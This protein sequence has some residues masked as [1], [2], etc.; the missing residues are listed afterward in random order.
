MNIVPTTADPTDPRLMRGEDTE[1]REMAEAY[2]V[3]SEEERHKK[4]VRPYRDTYVHLACHQL[5]K[6][7]LE[8]AETYARNPAFYGYT[9]CCNCRMHRP[10]NEFRWED[11]T[12]VGS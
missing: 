7:T 4:F 12:Q 2:L 3:L 8:I 10:L 6:M 5:T 11:G 9:Y 1:P